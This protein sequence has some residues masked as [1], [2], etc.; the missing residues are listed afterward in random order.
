MLLD[1]KNLESHDYEH[2]KTIINLLQLHWDY[3]SG[4]WQNF[5]IANQ[6]KIAFIK[7]NK[8]VIDCR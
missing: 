6:F 2:N 4:V 7:L 5:N 1:I 3:F 8:K